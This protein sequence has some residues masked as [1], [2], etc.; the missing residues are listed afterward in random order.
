[1]KT[2]LNT[3]NGKIQVEEPEVNKMYEELTRLILLSNYWTDIKTKTLMKLCLK[4]RSRKRLLYGHLAD[5]NDKKV[6]M[7]FT[8]NESNNFSVFITG[9]SVLIDNV[10]TTP[11][12]AYIKLVRYGILPYKRNNVFGV[13]RKGSL[14]SKNGYK[15]YIK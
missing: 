9:V 15:F 3:I 2:Y 5:S 6:N 4:A 13:V 1:M 11:E 7:F 8:H 12:E 14:L 10:E